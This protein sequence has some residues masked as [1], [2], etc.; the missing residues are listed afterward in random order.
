MNV[1]NFVNHRYFLERRNFLHDQSQLQFLKP[2]KEILGT[3]KEY[4][5][6]VGFEDRAE[7]EY[8]YWIDGSTA[9]KAKMLL[10]SNSFPGTRFR[11][12]SFL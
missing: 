8:I 5:L 9:V 7:S 12:L 10:D 6:N 2:E 1:T 4:D 3:S 11:I